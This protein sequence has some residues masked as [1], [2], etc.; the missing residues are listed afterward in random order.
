MP[1]IIPKKPE[2]TIRTE[3]AS[4]F[5]TVRHIARPRGPARRN[6]PHLDDL[7][8]FVQACEGLSDDTPVLIS[9]GSSNETG[10]YDVELSVR[11]EE[12]VMPNNNE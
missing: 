4:K 8:K 5:I 2:S 3:W 6:G 10:R 12:R 11:I 1:E 7:R 9:N